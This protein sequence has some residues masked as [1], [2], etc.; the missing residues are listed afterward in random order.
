MG[1]KEDREWKKKHESE[2]NLNPYEYS[3]GTGR[4][5]GPLIFLA[6]IFMWYHYFARL[7][8]RTGNFVTFVLE[9]LFILAFSC[10]GLWMI[11]DGWIKR[12]N[13]KY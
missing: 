9:P 6:T 13:I 5:L 10:G 4:F 1:V 2:I 12:K 8:L 11:Y 3:P 7:P